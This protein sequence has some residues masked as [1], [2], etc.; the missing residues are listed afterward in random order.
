MKGVAAGKTAWWRSRA[1]VLAIPYGWLLLF[2][3]VPFAIVLKIAFSQSALG[4]PPYTPLLDWSAGGW[5]PAVDGNLDNFALLLEDRL[6]ILALLG[7]VKTA[8]ISTVLC[9]LLGYPM[10]YAIAR[11]EPAWRYP[12]LMLVVLPFWTSFLI[13]SMRGSGC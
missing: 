10:A 8:L 5:L 6:Y 13:A 9:L 11:A 1:P 7:S 12:L 3:L 4:V 2:F